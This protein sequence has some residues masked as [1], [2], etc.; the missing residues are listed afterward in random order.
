MIALQLYIEGQ[1]VEMFKDESITLSQSIQDVK[2]ISKIFL[3]FSQTFSVPASKTNNKLFK[4]FYN[5]NISKGKAFDAREKQDAE[6]FLNHAFFRKGKIKLEGCTLKLNKPHTYKLTF[7]GQT[8]NLK[9]LLGNAKLGDLPLLADFEFEYTDANILSYMSDGLDIQI[10]DQTYFDALVFPLITHTQRLIYDSGSTTVNT[11]ELANVHYS[12]GNTKG[13]NLTEL[14]PAIRLYAIVKAIEARYFKPYGFKFL[15]T[16]FSTNQPHFYNLYMWL[17]NKT[18]SLFA[19]NTKKQQFTDFTLN[20]FE[21]AESSMTMLLENNSFIIP[22][23]NGS[24][25]SKSQSRT[26]HIDI[27]SSNDVTYTILMYKNGELYREF[28]NNTG[29]AYIS[30]YNDFVPNG[31]YTF[32]AIAD[33]PTTLELSVRGYWKRG[34][35]DL[36]YLNF[37]STLN[38]GTGTKLAAIDFMPDVKVIDFLTGLF[39]M[40]NLTSF[41]DREKNVI[42]ATL[43]DYYA[44]SNTTWDITQYID[45]KS[46]IVNSVLPYKQIEFKYEGTDSF[47]ASNH[48]SQFRKNWGGLKYDARDH[49]QS[50]TSKISGETYTIEVPF[51]HFKYERLVDINNS[52]ITN[53]QF[54]WSVDDSQSPLLGKPLIFYPV[55]ASGTDLSVVNTD[56][57]LSLKSSYF[58]PSNSM[59]LSSQIGGS[60]ISENINFGQELNEYRPE[61]Q[62]TKT[63]FKEFY[64]TYIEEIFDVK[65]RMTKLKAYLPISML[66]KYSLADKIVV[67]DEIYKINKVVTNFE[68]MLS[69]IELINITSDKDQIIPVRFIETGVT[70][71]TADSIFYKADNS[72]IKADKSARNDGLVTTATVDVVPESTSLPNNPNIVQEGVALVVTQPIIEYVTPTTATSSAIY[73]SFNVT[74]LGKVGTTEQIDEYGFFY[75]TLELDLVSTDIDT[76][77]ENSSVTYIAYPT[78]VENKFSLPS[79][80]NYQVTGLNNAQIFYRFYA[81]TNTNTDYSFGDA[82]SPVFF[83]E[84]TVSYSYT[85]TTDVRRYKITDNVTQRKTVRIMHYDGTLIDL[86][87]ITGFGNDAVTGTPPNTVVSQHFYSKILPIVIDGQPAT[88]AQ[89][90]INQYNTGIH[91]TSN[92]YQ[93][94]LNELGKRTGTDRGYSTTSRTEAEKEAKRQISF[95][96]I[97]QGNYVAKV[98]GHRLF[99]NNRSAATDY[100]FPFREGFSVYKLLQ[101]QYNAAAST[102]AK[103]DDGFYAYWG[104]NLDGSPNGSTGVSAHVINGVVTEVKLFY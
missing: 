1:E 63:L 72:L 33:N 69:D 18:G 104:Y 5:F 44:G 14:K 8:V 103:P 15:D 56:G 102:L 38:F 49:K 36:Q 64:S 32:E 31:T 16:F 13:V 7:F 52:S 54:G 62:Y 101:I 12:S 20:K 51:E 46:S 2:D 24:K 45:K 89:T 90:G 61:F 9:D 95:L 11:E 83:Q 57:T 85:E 71:I 34:L 68:T 48:L 10:G 3:E 43:D 58:V 66:Y 78:T 59:N 91:G 22:N 81:R 99:H 39:K 94:G 50:P 19:D 75:S 21:G 74:E 73:M 37:L 29:T 25:F 6:I 76:L 77:K 96:N 17:H 55:L 86:E 23:P 80:I 67:F 93:F 88:F 30:L 27:I 42:I 92:Q 65:R 40:F 53:I 4:H 41:I 100:V 98:T 79:Q 28:K 87:N 97:I 47:L 84:T 26:L 60:I 70:D 82:I 35:V